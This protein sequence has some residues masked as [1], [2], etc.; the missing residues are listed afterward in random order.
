M[1]AKFASAILRNK[2]IIIIAILAITVF[3]GFMGTKV[4]LSYKMTPL[5]PKTDPSVIEYKEYQKE[6]GEDGSLLVIGVEDSRLFKLEAFNKWYDLTNSLKKIRVE[7]LKGKERDT[8]LG[9][10]ESVSIASVYNLVKAPDEKKFILEN[11]FQKNPGSQEELDSLLQIVFS[12]PFYQDFI[13]TKDKTT[14]LALTLD[15]EIIDSESRHELMEAI[16]SQTKKFE[17][18]TNIKLHYS[19]L[20]Y[21]RYNNTT[22]VSAEIKLFIILSALITTIILFIFFRSIKATFFSLI[23][24]GIGVVWS[25][26]IMGICGYEIT[27]LTAL[28]PPLVIVIG[29]P[30]SVFLLNKY[31]REFSKHGNQIKS[32]QRVIERIGN[33][34][35]LTNFTT[36]LGFAT[37]IFTQSQG[38]VEFGV[39]ASLSV[40]SIF[41]LS[42]TLIPIIFSFL[43]E[44]KVKHTKHLENKWMGIMVDSLVKVVSKRRTIVYTV[45]I[46][47]FGISIW[48][49]TTIKTTGNLVDD[50]PKDD[51]ITIDLKEFFEVKFQGVLPL[52]IIIDTKKKGGVMQLSNLQKIDE[53]QTVLHEHDRISKAVSIVDGLKF[54]RQAY[55]NGNPQK[56]ALLNEQEKSFLAPYLKNA[57]DNKGLLK[58]FVD[59]LNQTARVSAQIADI[60]TEEMEAL[61]NELNKEID[62]IFPPEDYNVIVTG[63]STVFLKGTS[64]LVKNLF[65]S[66][67]IAITLIAVIMALLFSSLRMILISLVPNLLPLVI[68]GGL[69]G[70]LGVSIKPSTIL[71]FSIAFG[72]SVD[73]TIHYLAKYRQELKIR[74][75]DIK[76][77]VLLALKETGMSMIYTSVILFFGFGVFTASKF[78]GTIALGFLVSTTLLFAMLSNLVLLPSLL[79]TLEKRILSKA[80]KKEP[81]IELVDEEEDIDLD[82]LQINS[83]NN[84]KGTEDNT[85]EEIK[86]TSK[87]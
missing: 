14:L 24:V 58:A 66:L 34:T 75:W 70:I 52:E 38:L 20:P 3:M 71:V 57:G 77:S 48:G 37:F 17:E 69:M 18:E 19:G 60:G 36:S 7:K 64:Y 8:V 27:I 41:V 63:S 73:D 76:T 22:E 10:T 83:G 46:I 79:L 80:F 87:E 33:A 81:L 53:L 65:I 25:N 9:V 23:V 72:I 85:T 59:S 35:F 30:N 32:L 47:V 39:V 54:T 50:L 62:E 49:I 86:T 2:I 16:L 28:I 6:F 56:Y 67:L 42:I 68:T 82:F 74:P 26:G 78:G 12:L 13:Y 29:I 11:I 61:M 5:L 31:H 55:Y 84:E 1:W 40:M 44:P 51:P 21:I 45:A 4:E 43:S 15:K